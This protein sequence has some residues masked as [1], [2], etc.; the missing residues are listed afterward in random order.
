MKK[1]S[2]MC[3]A[4]WLG[5]I[6][7]AA[8]CRDAAPPTSRPPTAEAAKGPLVVLDER[9]REVG[10]VDAVPRS[11]TFTLTNEGNQPLQPEV[12]K[13]SCSCAEVQLPPAPIPPGQHGDV[14][15][16]WAPTPN[17]SGPVA[18]SVDLH[19][20]DPQTPLLQL[21]VKALANPLIRL[22]PENR[23][24]VDFDQL[25]PGKSS[26][27][28]VKVFSTRLA[29]FD[30]Q[31]RTSHP[32]LTVTTAPLAAESE[33]EGVRARSG[34]ALVVK[35]TDKLPGGYFTENLLLTVQPPGES[36]RTI[37]VPVYGESRS[38][39]FTLGPQEVQFQ[40]PR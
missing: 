14:T 5:L 9:R 36:A 35:T 20:N 30:L 27:R 33:V 3:P 26:E 32:G 7:M 31:A 15:L 37:E 16:R 8:G 19:T 1:C 10:E 13:K 24:F 34:Y 29:H 25:Q 11:Y 38:G 4:A 28:Q 2:Q 39:K 18:L 23:A 22:S 6:L 17:Q 40:K 21:E 12:E